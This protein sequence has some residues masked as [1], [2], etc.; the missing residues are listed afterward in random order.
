MSTV[1]LLF[2]SPNCVF[3]QLLMLSERKNL[4][5]FVGKYEKLL[6]QFWCQHILYTMNE[7]TN[8]HRKKW[9]RDK[10][11]ERKKR[12]GREDIVYIEAKQKKKHIKL[13]YG[14]IANG[15]SSKRCGKNGT[16]FGHFIELIKFGSQ[17]FN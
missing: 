6:M 10:G 3:S 9:A 7:W 16:T 5:Y 14:Q 1:A 8:E 12:R 2:F 17:N 4:Q 11:G 13:N 15:S